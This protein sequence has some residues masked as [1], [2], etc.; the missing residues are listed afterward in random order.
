MDTSGHMT[1]K[2]RYIYTFTRPVPT[3]LDRIVTYD[4][5]PQT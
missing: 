4:K 1:N 2:K 3:K 5:E